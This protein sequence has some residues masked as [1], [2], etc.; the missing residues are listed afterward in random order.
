M[1]VGVRNEMKMVC[2]DHGI[3][4]FWAREVVEMS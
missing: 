3:E 2:L 1:G 4:N